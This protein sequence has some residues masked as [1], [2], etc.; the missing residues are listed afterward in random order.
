MKDKNAVE[1]K[2]QVAAFRCLQQNS[3]DSMHYESFLKE[4]PT[5]PPIKKQEYKTILDEIIDHLSSS[6]SDAESRQA[7]SIFIS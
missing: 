3:K 6:D 7:S 1:M 5:L 2:I 4:L